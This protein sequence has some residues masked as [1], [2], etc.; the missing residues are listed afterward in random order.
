MFT[1]RQRLT[2]GFRAEERRRRRKALGPTTPTDFD[3]LLAL[4]KWKGRVK[5]PKTRRRRLL[6]KN[7]DLT[8]PTVVSPSVL[9]R[10][11]PPDKRT[12]RALPRTP[13][14]TPLLPGRTPLM[15]W[16]AT[17]PSPAPAPVEWKRL[18][19]GVA[20]CNHS[21]HSVLAVIKQ[22]TLNPRRDILSYMSPTVPPPT[23]PGTVTTGSAGSL[24]DRVG[25]GT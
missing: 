11:T 21:A 9:P 1:E 20:S 23:Q 12:P 3:E 13:A 22:G 10:A 2:Q 16:L 14:S 17:A 5:Q 18:R 25:I 4:H 8:A 19:K 6:P 24:S 7:L 15:D